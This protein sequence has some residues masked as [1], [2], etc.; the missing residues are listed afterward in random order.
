[1]A[2][3]VLSNLFYT[4]VFLCLL[5]FVLSDREP[6]DSSTNATQT[7]A[8]QSSTNAIH[9]SK[10]KSQYPDFYQAYNEALTT[11]ST[12]AKLM[13]IQKALKIAERSNVEEKQPLRH[14]YIMAADIHQERWHMRFALDN[15]VR[16]QSLGYERSTDS[17]I[18]QLREYL[19]K[20]ES[21]RSFNNDYVAT[22]GSG[23]AK[24]LTGKVIVAYVFIDDGINTRWS[25]TAIQ[26]SQQVLGEVEAW[27][28]DKGISYKVE[29]LSFT[30]KTF[31]VQRNPHINRLSKVSYKSPRKEIESFVSA[32]AT[33][34]GE[35][36]IGDFIDKQI[37]M[38]EADQGVVILHS[39]FDQ[40]SFARRCGYT[41]QKNSYRNG[42]LI[43]EFI[44]RCRDEYVMLM[45]QVKRN[46][47]DKLHYTQAHEMLH[48]FGADDLYSI[49]DAAN[50]AVTDIMNFH[51]KKLDDSEVHPIT[52]YAIGWKHEKPEAPFTILEK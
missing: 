33:G 49:K 8:R 2:A 16:A 30:N 50:Y 14:L 24:S 19:A 42:R 9:D 45:N 43:T 51:S 7:K 6:G 32:I 31:L 28:Q 25:K 35:R 11:T 5:L 39:N 27:N 13:A 29:E 52:A 26:R 4:F 17:R 46:R 38:E 20:I 48:L 36:S 37:Q 44:S 34:L 22:R 47:W 15:L 10:L 1:M 40:R 18:K 23:P 3:K 41:H 21:E 12:N